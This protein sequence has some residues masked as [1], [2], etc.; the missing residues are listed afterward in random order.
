[1]IGERKVDEEEEEIEIS[2]VQQ[3]T[4]SYNQLRESNIARNHE[5]LAKLGI[6]VCPNQQTKSEVEVEALENEE[7]VAEEKSKAKKTPSTTQR[8]CNSSVTSFLVETRKLT[9]FSTF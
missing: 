2:Q 4:L 7:D 5:Y 3:P 9:M 8:I 1:M 6:I